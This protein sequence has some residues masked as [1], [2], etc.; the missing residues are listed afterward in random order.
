MVAR[1]RYLHPLAPILLL[2][3]LPTYY[4]KRDRLGFPSSIVQMKPFLLAW[5]SF[6]LSHGKH[7][8]VQFANFI[9]L[10]T[11]ELFHIVIIE[12]LL[13][14]NQKKGTEIYNA[15]FVFKTSL[16]NGSH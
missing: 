10:K 2:P 9:C 13:S 11:A 15:F 1:E 8:K 5:F 7:T 16:E 4:L 6:S 3:Q 14:F 12:I